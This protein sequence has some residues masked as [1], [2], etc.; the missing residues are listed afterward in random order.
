MPFPLIPILIAAAMGATETSRQIS[1]RRNRNDS[2]EQSELDRDLSRDRL[3]FDQSM[4]NPFRHQLNQARSIN[5]LE[6]MGNSSYTRPQVT[7]GGAYGQSA[8]QVSGGFSFES[9]PDGPAAARA[10]QG[11]VMRGMT[12]PE[13]R[14]GGIDLMSLLAGTGEDIWAA[15]PA[16]TAVPRAT[17][18]RP[19][20]RLRYA[21]G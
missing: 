20:D 14:N 6:G 2:N 12:R 19:A 13:D 9:G 1:D 10:L 5:V 16:R 17:A 15:D 8:P 18:P 11:T 7:A 4:A 21:R 3:A